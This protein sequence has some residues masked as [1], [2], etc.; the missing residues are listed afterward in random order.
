MHGASPVGGMASSEMLEHLF[1]RFLQNSLTVG[2]C[3]FI[4]SLFMMKSNY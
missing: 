4:Q 2:R 3:Y 1:A